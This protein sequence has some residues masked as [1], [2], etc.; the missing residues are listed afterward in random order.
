MQEIKP[1]DENSTV[2]TAS[3]GRPPAREAAS[4][5]SLLWQGEIRGAFWKFAI[6]FS[7]VMNAILLLVVLILGL[8]LFDIKKAIAQPLVGG[9]YTSFVQMDNSR[10]E[11]TITVSDTIQV[12]DT[13]PVVFDL[14]LTQNTIV[15]TTQEVFIPNTL[16]NI[17][18]AV[19]SLNAPADI[20]LPPGTALPVQ[21]SLVVPVNQR[22]PVVLT[23][24]VRLTVPVDIPLNATDLHMPFSHLR[25]LFFP[26]ADGLNQLP[27]SWGEALSP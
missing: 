25:D 20:T 1:V 27:S 5:K 6:L 9:L 13:I 15:T 12:N 26:Y 24:P 14:P 18:S 4:R 16:V 7:F 2:R 17:R 23:V 3:D 19:L 10:I 22:V 21:L 8:L 11:T